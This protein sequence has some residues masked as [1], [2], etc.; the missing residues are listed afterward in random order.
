MNQAVR[1]LDSTWPKSRMRADWAINDALAG[2]VGS[3]LTTI[4]TGEQA[5]AARPE[6][7]TSSE[8][9]PAIAPAVATPL[10]HALLDRQY[11]AALDEPGGIPGVITPRPAIQTAACQHTTTAR[12]KPPTTPHH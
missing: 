6:G 5:M 3:P 2:L 7:L 12:H 1:V 9:A 4:E 10:I 8:T 11:P